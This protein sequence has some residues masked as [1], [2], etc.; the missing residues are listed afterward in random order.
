MR[1]WTIA[2]LL[3]MAPPC[4]VLAA[5]GPTPAPKAH[6]ATSKGEVREKGTTL[7]P[8][9]GPATGP[10][11]GE[12]RQPIGPSPAVKARR[13]AK[14][15]AMAAGAA[16]GRAEFNAALQQQQAQAH[17]NALI[18]RDLMIRRQVQ[19]QQMIQRLMPQGKT[20]VKVRPDGTYETNTYYFYNP[21]PIAPPGIEVPIVVPQP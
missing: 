20:V 16:R 9:V 6:E 8:A 21:A 7:K 4:S 3:L 12:P 17:Q 15:K 18:E 19:E 14:K 13:Q 1:T 10:E 5:Q 11:K 2:S